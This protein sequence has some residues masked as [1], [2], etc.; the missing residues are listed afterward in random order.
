MGNRNKLIS[1]IVPIVEMYF[2][3][4]LFFI[5]KEHHIPTSS[6]F[7]Y[8]ASPPKNLL[9]R[10]PILQ[11]AASERN[12]MI[13]QNIWICFGKPRLPQ[14]IAFGIFGNQKGEFGFKFKEGQFFFH[15]TTPFLS[16][17]VRSSFYIPFQILQ[18]PI[19]DASRLS[20]LGK[21]ML[22]LPYIMVKK[23]CGR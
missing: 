9:F 16:H 20:N 10:C 6:G 2:I 21:P 3:M 7:G 8:K 14:S 17:K 1:A 12:I 18:V 13:L 19:I 5:C 22:I 4:L 23:A 11:H 15:L